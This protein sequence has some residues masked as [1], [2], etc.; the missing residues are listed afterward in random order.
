[1]PRR[2]HQG[3][4]LPATHLCRCLPR[5]PHDQGPGHQCV[6]EGGAPAPGSFSVTLAPLQGQLCST[7]TPAAPLYWVPCWKAFAQPG[8]WKGPPAVCRRWWAMR[9]EAWRKQ[10]PQSGQAWGFSPVCR[11]QWAASEELWRKWRPQSGQAWAFWPVWIHWWVAKA[12]C[13]QRPQSGHAWGFSPVCRRRWVRRD[14]PCLKHFWH[15]GH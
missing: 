10:R 5:P 11:R 2:T 4:V 3:L 9:W 8:Q 15:S 12:E 1:M 7:R 6:G 13:P 14:E